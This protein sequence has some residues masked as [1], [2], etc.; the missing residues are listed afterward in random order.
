MHKG[1]FSNLSQYLM[2]GGV[3]VG[4]GGNGVFLI[5]TQSADNDFYGEIRFECKQ[6]VFFLV[7]LPPF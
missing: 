2:R 3:G 4:G 7:P 5:C 1:L 6:R